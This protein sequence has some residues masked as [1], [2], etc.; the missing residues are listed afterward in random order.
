[1]SQIALLEACLS[2]YQTT[3]HDY[4]CTFLKQERL[5]AGVGPLQ[6]IDVKFRDEP[7]SVAMNW[8]RN[9]V[10]ATRLLYVQGRNDNEVLVRPVGIAAALLPWVRVAPAGALAMERSLGPL[11]DFGFK[12]MTEI[13]IATD[14]RAQA[15]GD[16]V[17][18]YGGQVVVSETGR[19]ALLLVRRLPHRNGYPAALTNVFIDPEYMVPVKI[20]GYDWEGNLTF[21]YVY[22]DVHFN[23]GLQGS[24]F[25]PSG[26]RKIAAMPPHPSGG[27]S[28]AG[29]ARVKVSL[30]SQS[31]P[32]RSRAA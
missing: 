16:F 32:S 19:A 12:R 6:V 30:R 28:V 23:V 11:T 1:M 9:P 15:N 13:C 14:R 25:S 27:I 31:S 29:E 10:G 17:Q 18:E 7:F 26:G 22:T 20:E 21:R 4:T 8:V 3:Y 5:N 24:D 2:H